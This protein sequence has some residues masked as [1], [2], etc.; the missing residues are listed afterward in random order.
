MSQRTRREANRRGQGAE[1]LAGLLLRVKGYR[2][3]ARSYRVP[4]G[5]IDIIAGRGNVI[6]FIE[7]KARNS[8]SDALD[9]VSPT[10]RRRIARAAEHYL[11]QHPD[12]LG[13][14]IRFDVIAVLPGKWPKHVID[15]WQ[16]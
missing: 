6:S 15:A 3:L 7:V 9:A 13:R 16:T 8:L 10:Q 2:I 11:S 14:D 4:A 12:M 1:T 5:E